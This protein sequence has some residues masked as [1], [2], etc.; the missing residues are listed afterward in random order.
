MAALRQ[1]LEETGGLCQEQGVDLSAIQ[2]AEG[3]DRIGLLDDAV[4]ALVGSEEIRRR[5]IDLANTVQRVYKAVL[6][7][8]AAHEFATQVTP[9]QVV[10][11]EIRALT[12]PADIS[13]VMQQVEGLLDRS[14]APE[15]H[16]VREGPAPYGEDH[17]TDLSTI[18]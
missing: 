13:L 10:A 3:L 12:P 15:G 5:F 18:A 1:I 2:T 7:D 9:V 4:E 11:E 16:I 6:P 17:L 14:V 8:P